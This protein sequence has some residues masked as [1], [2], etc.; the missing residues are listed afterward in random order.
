MRA[1]GEQRA[2]GAADAAGDALAAEEAPKLKP[3]RFCGT[4]TSS[5]PLVQLDPGVVDELLRLVVV[6]G[7]L[8]LDPAVE[9]RVDLDVA[10][11]RGGSRPRA[12]PSISN[13]FCIV[14]SS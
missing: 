6:G 9:R 5:V 2:L 3:P 4:S 10:G 11:V 13:V 7:Q 1:G 8:H 12:C 14:D